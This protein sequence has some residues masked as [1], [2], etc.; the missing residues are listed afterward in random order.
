MVSQGQTT[1][2]LYTLGRRLK[3]ILEL[4]RS[5]SCMNSDGRKENQQM[6]LG[7]PDVDQ[8]ATDKAGSE[9]LHGNSY[10]KAKEES[11]S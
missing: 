9:G 10:K 11:H 6:S 3:F 7:E 5:H 8:E 4:F 2:T 1:R